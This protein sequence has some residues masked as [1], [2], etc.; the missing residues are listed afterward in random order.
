[1]TRTCTAAIL[2]LWLTAIP[3][4]ALNGAA[5]KVAPEIVWQK[6]FAAMKVNRYLPDTGELLLADEIRIWWYSSDGLKTNP[7]P[8]DVTVTL[9]GLL[10]RGS[11]AGED[12]AAGSPEQGKPNTYRNAGGN[13]EM[14]AWN[15]LTKGW[16]RIA[17]FRK[18]PGG[19]YPATL[20]SILGL[21]LFR[22][23][24]L[25]G[26]PDHLTLCYGLPGLETS[27]FAFR[28]ANPATAVH[29]DDFLLDLAVSVSGSLCETVP[30]RFPGSYFAVYDRRLLWRANLFLDESGTCGRIETLPWS[31]RAADFNDRFPWT[32][33]NP[34]NRKYTAPR[35]DLSASFTATAGLH[36]GYTET[37]NSTLTLPGNGGQVI[38]VSPVTWQDISLAASCDVPNAVSYCWGLSISPFEYNR[39]LSALKAEILTHF[40]KRI[41]AIE[42]AVGGPANM[43]MVWRTYL[44]TG[45]ASTA[46][47]NFVRAYEELTREKA[48]W[49][50]TRA[51]A[52]GASW[53]KTKPGDFRN[54]LGYTMVPGKRMSRTSWWSATPEALRHTSW[55]PY[56]EDEEGIGIDCGGLIYM[57]AS[58]EDNPYPGWKGS[59]SWTID[60]NTPFA[61]QRYDYEAVE[62]KNVYVI[63]DQQNPDTNSAGDE[64][65]PD[66]RYAVPGDVIYYYTEKGYHVMIVQYVEYP[67]LNDQD[68]WK[69][70]LAEMKTFPALSG[71]GILESTYPNVRNS[72]TLGE[73]YSSKVWVIARLKRSK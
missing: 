17:V 28:V 46:L 8:R 61:G 63:E 48:L 59:G 38:P 24:R 44:A 56:H 57:A 68:V 21:N 35:S 1:M 69:L 73:Q 29:G 20:E 66:V 13:V 15:R 31:S 10:D 12:P 26:D 18:R 27:R 65:Y 67:E 43:E 3:L 70:S 60:Y 2:A 9:T 53:V 55:W 14:Y 7:P 30:D 32:V 58:Y 72:A 16:D 62:N 22:L 41:D 40:G 52:I 71:I 19:T 25:S 45:Y 51:P 23:R 42:E 34:W 54:Y 37:F 6:N 11:D 36:S 49:D 33:G 5:G 64:I 39:R 50:D 4:P 47:K